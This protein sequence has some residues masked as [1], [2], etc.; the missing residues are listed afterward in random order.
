MFKR[1]VYFTNV[2]KSI[3]KLL[4]VT[5]VVSNSYITTTEAEDINNLENLENVT[6]TLEDNSS[7][8]SNQY[9]DPEANADDFNI[10]NEENSNQDDE[11]SNENE[12][13][14]DTDENLNNE[15]DDVI[16]GEGDYIVNDE[17]GNDKDDYVNNGENADVDN[18]T[19][20]TVLSEDTSYVA[21]DFDI[22][23]N[24]QGEEDTIDQYH[25]DFSKFVT[26]DSSQ[27]PET[28][29]I[30]TDEAVTISNKS[31]IE[32]SN[33]RIV[34]ESIGNIH[35][36]GVSINSNGA[37]Y[38]VLELKNDTMIT[39]NP[40]GFNQFEISDNG[41]AIETIA[42]LEYLS[43]AG[44]G[45][46]TVFY[47]NDLEEEIKNCYLAMA[48]EFSQIS[49]RAIGEEN[50]V[51]DLVQDETEQEET[52]QET[53]QQETKDD[54][55]GITGGV[56]GDLLDGCGFTVVVTL[57][58]GTT[59]LT[60]KDPAF[61]EHVQFDIVT[62]IL[63]INT[64]D[65]VTISNTNGV[66]D[67][68]SIAN[69]QIVIAE[70]IE[71]GADIVFDGVYM[72]RSTTHTHNLLTV[73]SKTKLEI[74]EV[75][76]VNAKS[77][78]DSTLEVVSNGKNNE[79]IAQPELI[80]LSGDGKLAIFSHEDD[81]YNY[82]S[83]FGDKIIDYKLENSGDFGSSPS[84]VLGVI[85]RGT[86]SAAIEYL[87]EDFSYDPYDDVLTIKSDK[88]FRI[89]SST[90]IKT[91]VIEEGIENP[92]DIILEGKYLTFTRNG[93]MPIIDV[94]SNA[95]LWLK[96]HIAFTSAT[97]Q[98]TTMVQNTADNG[99][100]LTIKNATAT[101]T[102][103][104]NYDF[105]STTANSLTLNLNSV[106]D[107][108]DKDV[109]IYEDIL[110]DEHEDTKYII[111]NYI[112]NVVNAAATMTITM[113]D[114]ERADDPTVFENLQY[115][116]GVLTISTDAK[117]SIKTNYA[118]GDDEGIGF[119]QLAIKIADKL[120]NAEGDLVDA[121]GNIYNADGTAKTGDTTTPAEANIT[122]DGFLNIQRT[123]APCI[124][125]GVPTNIEITGQNVIKYDTRY[126]YLT[127]N[128]GSPV[129]GNVGNLKTI[130]GNGTLD[131]KTTAGSNGGNRETIPTQVAK[132]IAEAKEQGLDTSGAIEVY[133]LATSLELCEY[134]IS[135]EDNSATTRNESE[136]TDDQVE[137][138]I[139]S[140][141]YVLNIKTPEKF[142][143]G[144]TTA[145]PY[146]VQGIVIKDVPSGETANVYLNG[147]SGT[148]EGRADGVAVLEFQ[149]PTTLA[150]V[151]GTINSFFTPYGADIPFIRTNSDLT[152]AGGGELELFSNVDGYLIEPVGDNKDNI[153]ITATDD[154]STEVTSYVYTKHAEVLKSDF[155]IA[156]QKIYPL[157]SMI[158]SILSPIAEPFQND[159]FTFN[160]DNRLVLATSKH[161]LYIANRGTTILG[162]A[163][164]EPTT[165]LFGVAST[166]SAVNLIFGGVNV[167]LT[168]EDEK[169]PPLPI[170][171][172]D[173]S[174]N[175]TLRDGTTN[176]LIV[177]YDLADTSKI[178]TIYVKAGKTVNITD[179]PS[180][181]LKITT[182][183][184]AEAISGDYEHNTNGGMILLQ[185]IDIKSTTGET[186]ESGEVTFD[187]TD[188]VVNTN[189]AVTI[190]NKN[191]NSVSE[192]FIKVPD[193]VVGTAN[194][195]LGGLNIYHVTDGG[196]I[197][198]IQS[199]TILTIDKN[200][201]IKGQGASN[202]NSIIRV[203]EHNGAEVVLKIYADDDENDTLTLNTRNTGEGIEVT[204]NS[205]LYINGG[206]LYIENKSGAPAIG[207]YPN[208]H[209][210]IYITGGNQTL[211][212]YSST[213]YA[214]LGGSTVNGGDIVIS[215]GRMNFI[216][217][218][219]YDR[220]LV[221]NVTRKNNATIPYETPFKLDNSAVMIVTRNPNKS[222]TIIGNRF[223]YFRSL[224]NFSNPEQ[225]SEWNGILGAVPNGRTYTSIGAYTVYGDVTLQDD[226]TINPNEE[227]DFT[228]QTSGQGDFPI[229]SLKT[230]TATFTNNGTIRRSYYIDK[231]PH[232]NFIPNGSGT[233][234]IPL[235]EDLIQFIT[236]LEG[237]EEAGS[238]YRG[239]SIFN[240]FKIQEDGESLI[241]KADIVIYKVPDGASKDDI[242][243]WDQLDGHNIDDLGTYKIVVKELSEST[244]DDGVADV[245]NLNTVVYTGELTA[246]TLEV[247]AAN[248]KDANATFNSF[249]YRGESN[250]YTEAELL[251]GM[252]VILNNRNLSTAD[253]DTP[254]Y[255]VRITDVTTD[256]PLTG[257]FDK[258][259]KLNV[260]ISAVGQNSTIPDE[261]DKFYGETAA[262]YTGSKTIEGAIEIAP[263]SLKD[264]TVT[265]TNVE[266]VILNSTD[267]SKNKIT[268]EIIYKYYGTDGTTKTQILGASDYTLKYYKVDA[269]GTKGTEI[270]D[271]ITEIGQVMLVI[272]GKGNFDGELVDVYYVQGDLS[273]STTGGQIK[274]LENDIFTAN[275]TAIT[276]DIGGRPNDNDIQVTFGVSDVVLTRNE[277]YILE[278]EI[279]TATRKIEITAKGINNY[280]N[281]TDTLTLDYKTDPKVQMITN[282]IYVKPDGTIDADPKTIPINVSWEEDDTYILLTESEY[283]IRISDNIGT[284]EDMLFEIDLVVFGKDAL[285]GT[286]FF[287]STFELKPIS[288]GA[289]TEND[290]SKAT[291]YLV[292][293][294]YERPD[295]KLHIL[296][297]LMLE[298]NY[299]NSSDK[300]STLTP[301]EKDEDYT[302]KGFDKN[303]EETTIDGDITSVEVTA[304]NSSDYTGSVVFDIETG[305]AGTGTGYNLGKG[306]IDYIQTV[307]IAGESSDTRQ[308]IR[309]G[310]KAEANG[311]ELEYGLH[312]TMEDDD[313]IQLD[314][315]DNKLVSPNVVLTLN[316]TDIGGLDG[317]TKEF[318]VTMQSESS[319]TDTDELF[320]KPDYSI[321]VN[322]IKLMHPGYLGQDVELTY[323]VDYTDIEARWS[324]SA[325]A[326]DPNDP[327]VGG[328]QFLG[329]YVTFT[330]SFLEEYP[331][332]KH[333]SGNGYNNMGA[334]VN[335]FSAVALSAGTGDT[336][337]K[338]L[339]NYAPTVY[340]RPDGDY[341]VE[342]FTLTAGNGGDQK[343]L[344]SGEHFTV[345]GTTIID[346]GK[347]HPSGNEYVSEI[348]KE[349][350]RNVTLNGLGDYAGETISFDMRIGEA[351]EGDGNDF[352]N[353]IIEQTK[354][355]YKRPDDI[356]YFEKDFKVEID[357]DR[358]NASDYTL[359]AYPSMA[360]PTTINV[361][362]NNSSGYTGSVKY[363]V[364]KGEAGA[365][366]NSKSFAEGIIDSVGLIYESAYQ[367]DYPDSLDMDEI[368]KKGLADNLSAN[369]GTGL[370]KPL[371]ENVDYTVTAI[372]NVDSTGS[373]R[374]LGNN[375][376]DEDTVLLTRRVHIKAV[377]GSGF[378]GEVDFL[379]NVDVDNNRFDI[380]SE[381]VKIYQNENGVVYQR[382]D[383]I[384]TYGDTLELILEVPVLTGSIAK[385]ELFYPK[386][387]HLEVQLDEYG[388]PE[389]DSTTGLPLYTVTGK[390]DYMG[391]KRDIAI[392]VVDAGE[393]QNSFNVAES[394]I[395]LINDSY[396]M[397][398]NNETIDYSKLALTIQGGNAFGSEHFT[399][400]AYDNYD[401]M[402]EVSTGTVDG[403]KYTYKGVKVSGK[404][405]TPTNYLMNYSDEDEQ[406][407]SQDDF[408]TML[409]D[410]SASNYFG[411]VEFAVK[412]ADYVAPTPA[413]APT[414]TPPPAEPD[415][416]PEV[417][418]EPDVEPETDVAPPTT[419]PPSGGN[420]GGSGGGSSGG[421]SNNYNNYD[422]DDNSSSNQS[423]NI[424]TDDTTYETENKWDNPFIDV[425][426]NDWFFNDV[427]SVYINNIMMGTSENTFEPHSNTTRAM[428]VQV[429][430]N[431]EGQPV[432]NYTNNFSDINENDWYFD[433]V[434]WARENDIVAG[435]D[436]NNFEP[437]TDI[438]R[439]QL[440]AI[441]HRYTLF[442]KLDNDDR[443]DLSSFSD[444]DSVFDY[445]LENMQWA[446]AN[447][448]IYGN[449]ENE[450]QPKA[451]AKRSE[452]S[453]VMNR[454]LN[455]YLK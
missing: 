33:Q 455:D 446:V 372:T 202:N 447:N 263:R 413:P 35:L 83:L 345:A 124:D 245:S 418:V 233:I 219:S 10:E 213:G 46:L 398:R 32:I 117:I 373:T 305:E 441:L 63:T 320:V 287:E 235:H 254:D 188:V 73:G 104:G 307:T 158:G 451:F 216:N 391:L 130:F 67:K 358:L 166:T 360:N 36:D 176:S 327:S 71:N 167:E 430:Y 324:V 269:D 400:T 17:N 12:N 180:S 433:A 11:T 128:S 261:A 309:D 339:I 197:V 9:N 193:T 97:G 448:I 174:V 108:D 250:P 316:A 164:V 119:R 155:V 16:N 249:I 424:E 367:L 13:L 140:T 274:V 332:F 359:D 295:K 211:E 207:N 151:D 76:T 364:S 442:K 209:G 66:E 405:A 136:L 453:A 293:T 157:K 186:F 419:T 57:D 423:N 195:T 406:N 428:V 25:E 111:N 369:V 343:E 315:V 454:Y 375:S 26:F 420:N 161:T 417:E 191:I 408:A 259:E 382:P 415:V 187:G 109:Y 283:S 6:N 15:S 312:Y 218:N 313:D 172:M 170:L 318:T 194:I 115:A 393:N 280:I 326:E 346:T 380:S 397:E 255:R 407:Y 86:A 37:L 152:M 203:G 377:E 68:D 347:I 281:S 271:D 163:T 355:V 171:S 289:G 160:S 414:P 129:I 74:K 374:I 38:P 306:I 43:L 396:V 341:Y 91:I 126:D 411:D 379:V 99:S 123:T 100:E 7:D 349:Y 317:T 8:N 1:R 337:S 437:H 386:D 47:H 252:N 39:V 55:L 239:N 262:T 394:I 404:G 72:T 34:V 256:E 184:G 300:S 107:D 284:E 232:L 321:D 275:P 432:N 296:D 31:D 5:L 64:D 290:F 175:I 410:S 356:L 201:T 4:A 344:K 238:G 70:G 285:S 231:N 342:D 114:K 228:V 40:D 122:L 244:I 182:R 131:I 50:N 303:G 229:P 137:L 118:T 385:V 353:G 51:D 227:L 162:G 390:G 145:N 192:I 352:S 79:T 330:D 297:D 338:G 242:T 429:L 276:V 49:L 81:G 314:I 427:Y 198:D 412:V 82:T 264:S 208:P 416:E 421:S 147:L 181:S 251:K 127:K 95:N 146:S 452:I 159:A 348:V 292:D 450:L 265:M 366:S 302:I 98:T 273:D 110:V 363:N 89:L 253:T 434:C 294:V 278:C 48:D 142:L 435:I 329:I 87:A 96:G 328:K 387:Y 125:L 112:I 279:D 425:F 439:E 336:F 29:T 3:A 440:V 27:L 282:D 237:G 234:E 215:G 301:L 139:T 189:K 102:Y 214:T 371:V 62:K 116:S 138:D 304:E 22:L 179:N 288:A 204:N 392:N 422:D 257:D 121:D 272:T 190:A 436:S 205:D 335:A 65:L 378:T 243:Q 402:P 333:E 286:N 178:P 389:Y 308:E 169:D 56:T 268:P 247:T 154:C 14:N 120:V 41:T 183:N 357:K 222:S 431:L 399:V 426:E 59:T 340:K 101:L 60:G 52:K 319:F 93:D 323:L 173:T 236:E 54:G 94:N 298:A 248:L 299:Y 53:E 106:K 260:T 224:G 196:P 30:H 325:T 75:S 225:A 217:T 58:N 134:N 206:N 409:S 445:A 199:D 77:K 270:T 19:S 438:T 165:H 310:L 331:H 143:L 2:K 85:Q 334:N 18:E 69:H 362:A 92:P 226:F 449:T 132:A 376:D 322:D 354:T 230:G 241:G 350:N 223:E 361:T 90:Y 24:V 148:T 258:A 395:D 156:D 185:E 42:G 212:V 177:P 384:Y 403:V 28:I 168:S 370:Y 210:D 368:I 149:S 200:N 135:I 311:L 277:D 133:Q 78:A 351:G 144:S 443:S 240:Y 61:A 267:N 103:G 153:T 221:G 220:H 401:D 141:P 291:L 365:N 88:T 105:S 444:S 80:T 266:S 84:S 20:D 381:D 150:I 246:R 21:C 113:L 23:I 388:N 45:T 44:D 383:G